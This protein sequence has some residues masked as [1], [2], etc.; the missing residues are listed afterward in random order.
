M[1]PI[2]GSSFGRSPPHKNHCLSSGLL[3]NT[4]SDPQIQCMDISMH[5][6]TVSVGQS[7]NTPSRSRSPVRNEHQGWLKENNSGSPLRGRE[8]TNRKLFGS[9]TRAVFNTEFTGRTFSERETILKDKRLQRGAVVT[10]ALPERTITNA[11]WQKGLD[12]SISASGNTKVEHIGKSNAGTIIADSEGS[13]DNKNVRDFVDVKATRQAGVFAGSRA[14]GTD[15]P[16]KVENEITNT[17]ASTGTSV[18]QGLNHE[19]GANTLKVGTS[20]DDSSASDIL[21]TLHLPNQEHLHY[22]AIIYRTFTTKKDVREKGVAPLTCKCSFPISEELAQAIFKGKN[23]TFA[24][25]VNSF[26]DGKDLVNI[27]GYDPLVRL[28][29][30]TAS[31]GT[32]FPAAY[33]MAA[34][35]QLEEITSDIVMFQ[36]IGYGRWATHAIHRRVVIPDSIDPEFLGPHVEAVVVIRLEG[37][38]PGGF[39]G[40]PGFDAEGNLK[41]LSESRNSTCNSTPRTSPIISSRPKSTPRRRKIRDLVGEVGKKSPCSVIKYSTPAPLNCTGGDYQMS[42]SAGS[43]GDHEG[44]EKDL[45][46]RAPGVKGISTRNM[47]AR[48]LRLSI[49]TTPMLKPTFPGFSMHAAENNAPMP[50]MH[51]AREGSGPEIGDYS[52]STTPAEDETVRGQWELSSLPRNDYLNTAA[53]VSNKIPSNVSIRRRALQQGTITPGKTYVSVTNPSNPIPG[54][55][56]SPA[57]IQSQPTLRMVVPTPPKSAAVALRAKDTALDSPIAVSASAR[58]KNFAR[59]NLASDTSSITGMRSHPLPTRSLK[60]LADAGFTTAAI[61]RLTK[62]TAAS[63]AKAVRPMSGTLSRPGSPEKE[64]MTISHGQGSTQLQDRPASPEKS[65]LSTAVFGRHTIPKE[66]SAAQ[67]TAASLAR[68]G[69]AK[70]VSTDSNIGRPKSRLTGGGREK[71]PVRSVRTVRSIKSLKH[72]GVDTDI[73]LDEQGNEVEQGYVNMRL[74]KF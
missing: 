7:Q 23:V 22:E 18:I 10:P 71:S 47:S 52:A 4:P 24:T 60:N 19:S 38:I 57:A 36:R 64:T 63:Q 69:N 15:E 33:L 41:P 72:E 11:P 56:L 46:K 55:I 3:S 39:V 43:D 20:S 53:V 28:P 29:I 32:S 54:T 61:N 44:D 45:V 6:P 13:A 70:P 62:N 9:P 31:D 26:G 37:F 74:T 73:I 67:P 21:K 68:A 14:M 16:V 35:R 50:K 49:S 66:F 12:N 65:S 42:Q 59:S 30:S 51:T 27:P 25:P 40:L 1:R 8:T 5:N 48:G 2:P 58:F 34:E 17:E